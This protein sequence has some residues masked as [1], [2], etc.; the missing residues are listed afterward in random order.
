MLLGYNTNG[1]AHHRLDEALR[2]LAGAGFEA[3]A[4]TPDVGQLDPYRLRQG[5]VDATRKLLDDLGLCCVIE[6]GA[7]FV[8]D[9]ARKHR[10]NLLEAD[11][12]ERGRRL[13]FLS[14][15]LDLAAALGARAVS[16]WAG[17]RPEGTNPAAAHERL[18]HGL[19][20]LLA[21]TAVPLALEPEPGMLVET[22]AAGLGVLDDL[23][24]PAG[25]GLTVDLGHLYVTGEGSPAAVLPAAA[26]RILQVHAEDIRRGVH[27]HLPPGSGDVD[28]AAAWHTLDRIGY[29]GPVCWELSRSSHAAPEMIQL[30]KELWMRR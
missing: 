12:A 13:D 18:R 2:L 6:T 3:V 19:T 1:L 26:G 25:L 14:R 27:E 28:F 10:P 15:C 17:A 7:R 20:H 29:T 8:L 30:V 4:L 24:N 22:V 21:K 9:P 16:L 5:E 11:A 23:G